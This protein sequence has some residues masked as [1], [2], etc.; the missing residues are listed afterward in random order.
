[1]EKKNSAGCLLKP[2]WLMK[3]Y[4]FRGTQI[5]SANYNVLELLFISNFVFRR[6][7]A[8]FFFSKKNRQ[9]KADHYKIHLTNPV[10]I[11]Q[12]PAV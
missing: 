7:P 1:L 2:K 8:E 3:I 5:F 4:I 10:K 6:Q 12:S 11:L 9:M